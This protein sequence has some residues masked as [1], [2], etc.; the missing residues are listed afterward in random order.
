VE[1]AD[2]SAPASKPALDDCTVLIVNFRTLRH[3]R[4]CIET[5]RAAYP[6]VPLLVVDNGSADESTDYLKHLA[7]A[8]PATSV[9]FNGENVY[10]GPA[11]HQGMARITTQ[12]AFLFDSDCEVMRGGFLELMLERFAA[13]PLLYAIGKRGWTNWHGYSPV[14]ERQPHTAY[15]HPFACMVD[16]E[17]YFTLPPFVHHGAPLWRNM[18]GARRAGYLLEHVPIEDYILHHGEV[19][20]KVHGYGYTHLM[21]LQAAVNIWEG[22]ARSLV[23]RVGG[24]RLHPPALP[25]DRSS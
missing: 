10:H 25:T 9:L 8:D 24:R 11:L 1:E 2:G 4:T 6:S 20:A 21:R 3:T 19:T 5:L 7:D 23:A 22:R 18:W 14:D 15:V 13:E 17:K 16:R 12:Y